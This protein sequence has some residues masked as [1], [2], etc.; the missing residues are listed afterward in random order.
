MLP[1]CKRNINYCWFDELK[2]VSKKYLKMFHF[3]VS[4]IIIVI[5]ILT[6]SVQHGLLNHLIFEWI[7]FRNWIPFI[8]AFAAKCWVCTNKLP[9]QNFCEDPFDP[10]KVTEEDK[11]ISILDCGDGEKCLKLYIKPPSDC[12][13]F[14]AFV[15]IK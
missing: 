14:L 2:I 10:S 7:F 11:E 3:K 5:A 12:M 6:I 4:S 8:L 15:F 1:D 13:Y 9:D